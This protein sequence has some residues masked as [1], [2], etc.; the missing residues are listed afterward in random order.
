MGLFRNLSTFGMTSLSIG[1]VVVVLL[2]IVSAEEEGSTLDNGLGKHIE[3]QRLDDGLA[4][5][6][7]EG[8]PLMLLI[9]KSWCGACKSLK[10]KFRDSKKIA[11]LSQSFVMVN[12]MDN[13][14][15]PGDIYK[16]DGGYVPRLFFFDSE[17]ELLRDVVNE[18]GNPEYKYYYYD[19][20]SIVTSMEKVAALNPASDDDLDSNDSSA[21]SQTKNEL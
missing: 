13:D 4:L 21:S 18:H 7:K 19:E 6:K 3:W 2:V 11:K 5:A 16:P 1:I 10:P 20:L 14:E 15:P 12:T 8:K 9:H 17:G